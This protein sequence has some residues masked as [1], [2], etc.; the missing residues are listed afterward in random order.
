MDLQ[1][2]AAISVRTMRCRV[3]VC[4]IDPGETVCHIGLPTRFR[5]SGLDERGPCPTVAATAYRLSD[6]CRNTSLGILPAW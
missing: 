5:L 6:I 3:F 2:P 1:R 4:V